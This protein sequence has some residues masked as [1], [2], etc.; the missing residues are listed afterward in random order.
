MNGSTITYTLAGA[1]AVTL[2]TIHPGLEYWLMRGVNDA[3]D[4]SINS[5]E[6]DNIIF[7]NDLSGDSITW[8]TTGEMIGNYIHVKSFYVGT[9]LKWFMEVVSTP[10]GT[11]LTGAQAYAIA[12]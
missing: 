7:G 2:P 3:N 8:T 1:V 12:T 11:G 10:L 9:A 5:A 4:Y 6:G